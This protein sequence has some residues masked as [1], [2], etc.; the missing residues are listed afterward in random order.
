MEEIAKTRPPAVV[1]KV[2]RGLRTL[3]VELQGVW[4]DAQAAGTARAR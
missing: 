1:L 3:F 4:P 2:R